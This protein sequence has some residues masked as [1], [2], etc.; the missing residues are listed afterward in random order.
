MSK[1]PD[2][3]QNL[4]LNSDKR[5]QYL[6]QAAGRVASIVLMKSNQAFLLVPA[7]LFSLEGKVLTVVLVVI[8]FPCID[9]LGENGRFVATLK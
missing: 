8:T 9:G 1:D 7:E 5:I 3:R 4:Y 6:E 2:R